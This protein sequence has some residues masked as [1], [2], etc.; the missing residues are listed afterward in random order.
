MAVAMSYVLS[1]VLPE[2]G[3]QQT[4]D[5]CQSSVTNTPTSCQSQRK[6]AK[7]IPSMAIDNDGKAKLVMFDKPLAR[8]CI[9]YD[10]ILYI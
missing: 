7:Q 4:L 3:G 6:A 10:I 9:I 8:K 1:N 2:V 5:F